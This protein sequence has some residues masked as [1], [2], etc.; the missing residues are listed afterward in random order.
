MNVF[1]VSRMHHPHMM[2]PNLDEA[3]RFFAT[4]F[5]REKAANPFSRM[6]NLAPGYPTGYATMIPIAEVL[7][8]CVDP[9]RYRVP[10]EVPPYVPVERPYLNGMGW[11]IQGFR[12]F[13]SE[14]R[15]RGI[16]CVS[17]TR[18]AAEG[19]EPPLGTLGRYPVL[20]TVPDDTGLEFLFHPTE[21]LTQ[22]DPRSDP[23]WILPPVTDDDPLGIVCCAHHTIVTRDLSRG[24]R[25]LVDTLGGEVIH[26][27]PDAELSAQC[28][29]IQLAD[30]II[31]YAV[32]SDSVGRAA[33]ALPDA[34]QYDR[35]HS[36]EWLVVDIDRA[37]RHLELLGVQTT[38]R[39]EVRLVTDSATSLGVPWG[40]TTRRVPGDVADR[41]HA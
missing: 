31:A 5:G 19:E 3:E 40:F 32:P 22:V 28:T 26:E 30:A 39:D 29:Y 25:F 11:G 4:V 18:V 7:M 38:F 12:A 9:A 35:Y 10:G 21:W 27:E 34:G 8:D 33:Q 20:F 37:A 14:L 13:Y 6:K 41:R 16:R 15:V 24:L 23:T 2:V 1:D 17:Q 36:I